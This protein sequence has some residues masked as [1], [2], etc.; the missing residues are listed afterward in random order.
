MFRRAVA[1]GIE[2][3]QFRAEDT[4]TVFAAVDR[5]RGYLRQWLPWVD[6]SPSADQV[7]HFIA[8][9]AAQLDAGLG[10]NC[11]IWLDGTFAGSIGCHP[12]DLADRSCAIGY[13]IAAGY[14]GKGTITRCCL[15]LID[16]LFYEAGL[17]RVEIRCGTGNIRS[18]AI[19]RRLGFIREGLLREAQWVNDRWIDLEV[20]GMLE[21]HWRRDSEP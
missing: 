12:F 11:G 5:N 13:W 21:Q 8:R 4:A 2:M 17:H 9:S 15:S 18:C 10:P 19:P 14:Q 6:Q 7:G 3:R 20:W 1:D 16:Y